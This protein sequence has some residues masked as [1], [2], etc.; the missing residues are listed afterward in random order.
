M[1]TACGGFV[2]SN[3]QDNQ[4]EDHPINVINT[5]DESN[6]NKSPP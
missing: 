5:Q 3:D 1:I 2:D 6:D 4:N